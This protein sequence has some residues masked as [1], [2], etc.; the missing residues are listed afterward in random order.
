M[1]GAVVWALVAD[2]LQGEVKGST[3]IVPL[4]LLTIDTM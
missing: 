1:I 2:V 3:D 4:C